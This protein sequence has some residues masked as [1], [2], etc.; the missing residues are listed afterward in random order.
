MKGINEWISE[1]PKAGIGIVIAITVLMLFSMYTNG[2][3]T[4]MNVESFMPDMEVVNAYRDVTSNYTE[5]YTVQIL[6]RSNNGDILN[7]ESLAE[8]FEVEEA[9]L[10]NETVRSN[11]ENPSYPEGNI[12]SLPTTLAA[13]RI[14]AEAFMQGMNTS[15]LEYYPYNITQ[16]RRA[17]L[18]ENIT[19]PLGNETIN[20]QFI[21]TPN[22]VKESIR[23]LSFDPNGKV[24]LEYISRTLTKD[25][26]ISSQNM[27]ADG[28]VI[29][30]SL[31]P[32]AKDHLMLEKTIDSIV[33]GID[34]QHVKMDTLG[35]RLIMDEIVKA[36]DK[37]M[38]MLM[39]AAVIMI[40]IVLLVVFRSAVDALISLIA[41][42]FS[43]IWMYGFG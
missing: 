11:L 17:L 14:V 20:L 21:Y 12:I 2:V 6:V 8:V 43:I 19:I 30:I 16:M 41:L 29:L 40:I 35:S 27:T 32:E 3:S 4:Q 1:H 24:A 25:F 42:A 5:H 10:S 13:T 38:E 37:S 34:A 33:K 7:R 15:L 31:N 22:N 36:S 23:L 26:N 18:G 39:P 28:C 9:L